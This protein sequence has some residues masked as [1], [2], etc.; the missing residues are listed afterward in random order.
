MT[1]KVLLAECPFCGFPPA[2]VVAHIDYEDGRMSQWWMWQCWLDHQWHCGTAPDGLHSPPPLDWQLV[3]PEGFTPPEEPTDEEM[4]AHRAKI[5]RLIE[6]GW[7]GE[8]N[9]R[10]GNVWRAG[11]GNARCATGAKPYPRPPLRSWKCGDE[12]GNGLAHRR[13][14]L[15]GHQS[16]TRPLPIDH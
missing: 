10:S 11:I 5:D 8:P 6:E 1:T 15:V 14:R 2:A 4:A 7:E 13:R 12:T 16:R 3:L 9:C